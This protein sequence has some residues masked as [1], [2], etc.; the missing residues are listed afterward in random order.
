MDSSHAH[1][2]MHRWDTFASIAVQ[3]YTSTFYLNLANTVFI[4]ECFLLQGKDILKF[5]SPL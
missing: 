4:S 2:S 5:M 3:E 1:V